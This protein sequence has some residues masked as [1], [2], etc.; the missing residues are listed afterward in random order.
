MCLTCVLF[1]LIKYLIQMEFDLGYNICSFLI[2]NPSLV[3]VLELSMLMD[4]LPSQQEVS[5]MQSFNYNQQ[6]LSPFFT[7]TLSDPDCT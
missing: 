5:F 2:P 4:S 1:W 3:A 7:L 6:F